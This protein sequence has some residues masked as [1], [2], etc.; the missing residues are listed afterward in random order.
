M[1]ISTVK[2]YMKKINVFLKKIFGKQPLIKKIVD[3]IYK[4]GGNALLVGGAV[5]D[6]LLNRV[7]KDID[8][9]L[10]GLK[11]DEIQKILKK[12]GNVLIVGKSFGVLRLNGLDVDWSVP[13]RDSKGRRPQVEV[14]PDMSYEDAFRR[15]DL[16]INAMGI[17][18]KTGKL[19]DPFGGLHDLEDKKL[20]APDEKLFAEDP[21]RFFRVMQFI[22]RFEMEPD[23]QLNKICK[24]MDLSIIS[25]E[26][27]E[28]EFNKLFL[29]SCRP[30]LGI[31]WL[32]KIGR[33]KEILPEVDILRGIKQ[34]TRW[35]PEGDVYVHTLQA[36]DAMAAINRVSF[37]N[38]SLDE[39]KKLMLMWAVLCHD[40][41]KP[42]TSNEWEPGRISAHGHE[43][44]GVK[45]A[46]QLLKRFMRDKEL[47][48]GVTQLVKYHMQ[49]GQFVKNGAKSPAYK[50]LAAKIAPV[51]LEELTMV[52]CADKLARN[53][54]SMN[55]FAVEES[56]FDLEKAKKICENEFEFLDVAKKLDVLHAIEK[57]VLLGRDLKDDVESGPKMGRLLK[58]AY[59]I[60]IEEGIK[61]KRELRKRILS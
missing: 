19:I 12:F 1:M 8:I 31:E 26:R 9:E 41:G 47:I 21:L 3:E 51:T 10:Y 11:I 61:N 37:F 30:S 60:Q 36:L 38:K 7:P 39:K 48:D 22:G 56:V 59:E 40:F 33:L 45:P 54:R 20:R 32:R 18:L 5:R 52:A 4:E 46:K 53:A 35:H 17:D 16:T 34:D 27:I 15:R 58:R 57:P 25:R 6:V 23:A 29:K 13:R 50:K 42:F 44:A 28:S 14:D 55:P 49:P 43:A 2:E 24:K